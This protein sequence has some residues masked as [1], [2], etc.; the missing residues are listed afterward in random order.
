MYNQ[1]TAVLYSRMRLIGTSCGVVRV[2]HRRCWEGMGGVVRVG[3]RRVGGLG[4]S[5]HLMVTPGA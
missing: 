2:E 1:Y 3:H 4:V 5:S